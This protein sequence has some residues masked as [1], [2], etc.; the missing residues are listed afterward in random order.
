MKSTLRF[1]VCAAVLWVVPVSIAHADPVRVTSGFVVATSPVEIAPVAVTGTQG[2][3]IIGLTDPTEG[4]FDA[5]VDCRPCMPGDSIGFGGSL[6]AFDATATLN[7]TTYNLELSI[8]SP[9][10]TLWTL[11][12]GRIA[13]PPAQ[14]AFKL[15]QLPFTLSG[16]FFPNSQSTGVPLIGNGTASVLL[17]P[18]APNL[19][20]PFFWQA[21]LVH[22]DFESAPTA[23]PEPASMSLL[24]IGLAGAGLRRARR[25]AQAAKLS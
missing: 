20:Q 5:F 1:M 22:Y 9:S 21:N 23:T 15:L 19:G 10:N 7:G 25:R 17:T 11:T 14:Q 13:A 8:D 4:R 2:F 16:L 12:A 3:S 6:G 18:S 24:L